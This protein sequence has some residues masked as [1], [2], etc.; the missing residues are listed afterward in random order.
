MNIIAVNGWEIT[1]GCFVNLH[2]KTACV[3]NGIF[4]KS[5]SYYNS[6]TH[7]SIAINAFQ[8]LASFVQVFHLTVNV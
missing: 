1:L 3:Y 8:W 5:N 6:I 4:A 7:W 2:M